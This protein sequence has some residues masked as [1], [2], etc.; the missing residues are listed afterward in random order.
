MDILDDNGFTFK[1]KG[2]GCTRIFEKGD[3]EIH[4]NRCVGKVAAFDS[5]GNPILKRFFT[6]YSYRIDIEEFI[7][8]LNEKT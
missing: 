3:I 8:E 1:K 6:P 2:A 4:L 5:N 7:N